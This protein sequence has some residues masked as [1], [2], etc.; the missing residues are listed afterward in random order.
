MHWSCSP[1]T[2]WRGATPMQVKWIKWI[3]IG[4]HT[5]ETCMQGY[6]GYF[7]DSISPP[8]CMLYSKSNCLSV[9]NRHETGAT[10]PVQYTVYF[11]RS[12]LLVESWSQKQDNSIINLVS[13]VLQLLYYYH[14]IYLSFDLLIAPYCTHWWILLRQWFSI[15]LVLL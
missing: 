12:C 7:P 8:L 2:S 14:F 4:G 9:K 13:P 6:P 15:S 3:T 10:I 11:S 5:W 1:L